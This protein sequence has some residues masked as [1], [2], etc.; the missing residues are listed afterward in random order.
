MRRE[1]TKINKFGNKKGESATNTQEIQG[2][3]DYFG[4]CIFK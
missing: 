3:R 1:K 2:I 4:I